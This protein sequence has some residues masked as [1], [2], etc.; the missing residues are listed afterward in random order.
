MVHW[1]AVKAIPLKLEGHENITKTRKTFLIRSREKK[2][3]QQHESSQSATSGGR[4]SCRETIYA[5][6]RSLK[7][8]RAGTCRQTQLP[9]LITS[10]SE[11]AS[12]PSARLPPSSCS[13][14]AERAALSSVLKDNLVIRLQDNLGALMWFSWVEKISANTRKMV[15][16]CPAFHFK[17][18]LGALG[19]NVLTFCSACG[20]SYAKC[21]IIFII[22]FI[23]LVIS[24]ISTVITVSD[25]WFNTEIFIFVWI[26]IHYS[27]LMEIT[28]N[29]LLS[30]PTTVSVLTEA[31]V[32]L[33]RTSCPTELWQYITV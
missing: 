11:V 27:L 2:Q 7:T 20:D 24:W 32:E 19:L 4:R 1:H 28:L 5:N 30:F 29:W 8:E 9:S 3:Q 22:S 17:C 21:L 14:T 23:Y 16:D 25:L 6:P 13:G 26:E 10:C 12:V 31:W 15:S 33:T 18:A